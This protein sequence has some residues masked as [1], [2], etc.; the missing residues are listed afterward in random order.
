[1]DYNKT[2][3][4]PK[5]EF[6][7]RA[8]LPKKEPEILEKWAE[9]KVFDGIME[10]N[11]GRPLY[12]LHD[13]PPY[14]NG[15]IHLGH[16][17]NKS[18]KDFVVRSKNMMG[19][20]SPYIPGWDTH[21]LPIESQVIKKYGNG[22]IKTSPVEFRK[23]CREFALSYAANQSTQFQRLGV[24]G[25][26][27][28]P[29]L[30]LEPE[31]E[32]MQ[33]RVFG[34]MAKK[35]YIYKGM[36][37]VYWCP[38]DET[39]LAEAEIEYHDDPCTAVFVR[40]PLKDDKGKVF[41]ATGLTE[42]DVII[43]TTTVWT[44]PGNQAI[45]LNPDLEYS[46]MEKD[47]RG[48]LLASELAE[49]VLKLGGIEGAKEVLRML[50]SEFEYMTALHPF[51][52]RDSLMIV[53]PHVNL[54]AGSGCVHTAPGFGQEDFEICKN[55]EGIPVNVCVDG[56][57][58]MT[59]A[60]GPVCAG[61]STDDAN[62]AILKHIEK[63]GSLFH[64]HKIVHQYPHCWRCKNPILFRVTEQWF[65]SVD[66]FKEAALEAIKTVKWYP[67]WGEERI[68]SMV[69]DRSDWCISRQRLWGVPIPMFYCKK[70]GKAIID[71]ITVDA[72]ARL[73]EKEGSDAWY[74]MSAAEILPKGYTC[75]CGG[76]EFTKETDIMDVWF[77]SGSSHA[78]VLETR[79]DQRWPADMYLE[80]ND[81]HRGW[82]QSSLLTAVATRG[83]A[84]Y[85]EVLT[86]GM[87]VDGE[88][89]KM[90]KSLGNGIAPEEIISQYG[91]DILRL[92]VASADY[93]DDMRISPEIL[94]QLSEIYRKIRNTARYMLGNLYDF[95]PAV[96]R[97]AYE[98]MQELD[99]WAL[100]RLNEVVDAVNK[101][102]D[103]Y[104]YY[105][106]FHAI[107]N[108]CVVDMSNFYL[109]V[110]KDRLYCED[111]SGKLRRSAQSAM[112]KILESITLMLAPILSFTAEE[113]WQSM[114]HDESADPRSVNYN[115]IPKPE[116]LSG[117]DMDKWGKIL[118]L[119]DD[120]KKALEE[121]RLEK[122]IGSSL[123][124]K[125]VL[126]RDKDYDFAKSVEDMLPILFI[127]SQVVVEKGEPAC[128]V[129][130]AEGARCE[131]CWTHCETV[132]SDTAHPTLCARCAAVVERHGV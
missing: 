14:A 27:D 73:F 90:S 94:K 119:R 122:A 102:Y 81:Q 106:V 45:C 125:V 64:K 72:V 99:K 7:M 109:D 92:W 2:I 59:E 52:D 46:I 121:S 37:A 93:T 71:D 60:A 116:K 83:A 123:D 86:C 78:A 89:K 107:H 11:E 128:L 40:F 124:A 87:V 10:K 113:I 65:C 49:E 104:T 42:V 35:G 88:G 95:D 70:C 6:S 84:P 25:E 15:D 53:G 68:T 32:A 63:T 51:M 108:Y 126:R 39:A 22:V 1:M 30:T 28:K 13:G 76:T 101:S 97:V 33:I 38:H 98:D 69:R 129:L 82:F 75:A 12:I 67:A 117:V 24:L 23:A 41:A 16:A 36:K 111:A 47:G 43:W 62:I 114:P 112:Y 57:G 130:P 115:D 9:M 50:G 55:Y 85:R 103:N 8:G 34:E 66:G 18:L 48:Y 105:L 20:K 132:G 3:N 21:G 54:D 74:A 44:L 4:L 77:D 131:R 17:L 96:D 56:K 31:F 79:A 58:V 26:W 61:L 127:T 118:A 120:A 5:T 110:I 29:Y 100:V 91:A 19:F 80:G